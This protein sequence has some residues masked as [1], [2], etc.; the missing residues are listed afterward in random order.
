MRFSTPTLASVLALAV[1][2]GAVLAARQAEGKV[3][4]ISG[5]I[6]FDREA[7][8]IARR[9]SVTRL[10]MPTPREVAD[11]RRAVIYLDNAP[12]AAFDPRSTA[13]A[14]MTQRNE[15]FIPHLL[16][17][18]VGTTVDFPNE[19]ET[20]HNVFSLSKA[21]RFDL[22]RYAAGRSKPVRF[23][24]PGIVRVFCDIHSH[25]SAFVLVFNH[26]FFAT[27]DEDGRYSIPDVPPG[28]YTVMAWNDGSVRD[29]RAVTVPAGGGTV[30]LDFVLR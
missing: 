5:Q 7:A 12:T 18:R 28:R 26:R 21:R 8:A 20:Y 2:L 27:S 29:S 10:G 24:Q 16:A 23:D 9:P 19:D 13:R 1:P 15:T 14:E 17:V 3:G 30:E 25:M 4:S 6:E 22:G 11:R